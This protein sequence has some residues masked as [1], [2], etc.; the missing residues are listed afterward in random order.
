MLLGILELR[1]ESGRGQLL[2][3][4]PQSFSSALGSE[5]DIPNTKLIS[6]AAEKPPLAPAYPNYRKF[7]SLLNSPGN[8]R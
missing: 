2:Q 1:S 8:N 4:C 6:A 3:E 7:L 5:A